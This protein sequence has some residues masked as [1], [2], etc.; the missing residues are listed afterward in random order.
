MLYKQVNAQVRIISSQ[1]S[2]W[3]TSPCKTEDTPTCASGRNTN[4][5]IL[6]KEKRANPLK[7]VSNFELL[8][9]LCGHFGIRGRSVKE[10]SCLSETLGRPRVLYRQYRQPVRGLTSVMETRKGSSALDK[11]LCFRPTAYRILK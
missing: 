4:V 11:R 6:K 1:T 10:W 5:W 2:K 8:N 9:E 3:R 7:R